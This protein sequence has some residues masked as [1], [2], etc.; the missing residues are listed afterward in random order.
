LLAAW[1]GQWQFAYFF[2]LTSGP[3]AGLRPMSLIMWY[4]FVEQPFSNVNA[5]IMQPLQLAL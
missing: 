5:L 1:L 4:F 3:I 2:L